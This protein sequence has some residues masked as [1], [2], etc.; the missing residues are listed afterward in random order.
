MNN[1]IE[2]ILSA[3]EKI[4]Q[5]IS[6]YENITDIPEIERDILLSAIRDMY[7]GLLLFPAAK[8][9]RPARTDLPS[10]GPAEPAEILTAQTLP[11]SGGD[12]TESETE[13]AGL[14]TSTVAEKVDIR[15]SDQHPRP[16]KE[17]LLPRKSADKKKATPEI[18][19]DKLKGEKQFV[20]ETLAEKVGQQNITSKLQSKPISKISS[21]IGINDKFKLIRDL[22]NEDS[23]SYAK[24]IA[25]LDSCSDFNE[26][27]NYITTSFNW[28]ME[29]EPVQ[30][31]LDL[32]RR[33]FIVKKDE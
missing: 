23:E 17:A 2:N 9:A 25:R 28:D 29:E 26:A 1:K 22:F 6:Q 8:P 4:K 15:E 3:L 12:S 18:L 20:Y 11:G 14:I 33:K 21:A 5:L 31:L 13:K 19:G 32:V 10:S 30:F 7:S 27:F 24:T 16:K